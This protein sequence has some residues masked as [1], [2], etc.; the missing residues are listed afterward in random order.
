MKK[1]RLAD[2]DSPVFQGATG[3]C[4]GAFQL[5]ALRCGTSEICVATEVLGRV[6]LEHLLE[7]AEATPRGAQG[8][9]S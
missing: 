4:I 3:G 2:R 9:E 8:A 7:V 6:S 1:S 5:P